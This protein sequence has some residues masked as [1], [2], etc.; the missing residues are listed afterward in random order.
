[1]KRITRKLITVLVAMAMVVT[2]SIVVFAD[3]STPGNKS[4]LADGTYRINGITTNFSMFKAYN[5]T[6]TLTVKDGKMTATFELTGTGY[7]YIYLGEPSDAIQA[8]GNGWIKGMVKERA[9]FTIPVSALDTDI[10]ISGHSKKQNKWYGSHMINFSSN[11]TKVPT[12]D[13]SSCSIAAL[14]YNGAEQTPAVKVSS[15]GTALTENTDFMVYYPESSK[16]PGTYSVTIVGLGNYGGTVTKSYIIDKLNISAA[17]A[18]LSSGSFTYTGK[19]VRPAVTVKYGNSTLTAGT[20]YTAAFPTASK[21]VGR[22]TVTLT[23]T[24]SLTGTAALTYVINPQKTSLSKVAKAAKR[25]VKVTWR[26]QVRGTTG[27][28]IQYSLKSSF[29]NAKVKT[30]SRNKTVKVTVRKLKSNKKYYFRVRTYTKNGSGY[31]YSSW[32]GAKSVRVR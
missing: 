3:N 30:I 26:K 7:D 21:N 17:A 29:K 14:T 8:A 32:S 27:Y 9:R 31:Y 10:A 5:S 15:N 4:A 2:S 23:G 11:V 18:T 19:D 1:M 24:G 13:E 16:T 6:G 22:Y 28:Q 20:D 25:A 12:L